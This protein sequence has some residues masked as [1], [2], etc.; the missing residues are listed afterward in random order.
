[1]I[2]KKKSHHNKTILKWKYFQAFNLIILN[3]LFY[4]CGLVFEFIRFNILYNLKTES[5]FNDYLVNCQLSKLKR[6]NSSY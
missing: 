6:K 2:K 5:Y 3:E 4:D 1:M